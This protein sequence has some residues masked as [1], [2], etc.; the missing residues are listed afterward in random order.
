[1]RWNGETPTKLSVSHL[2]IVSNA[3]FELGFSGN[4]TARGSYAWPGNVTAYLSQSSTTAVL[5]CTGAI[6]S[7][8][9]DSSTS[10]MSI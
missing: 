10:R 9:L 7:A 1:M 5:E 3:E 2:S 8:Q 6:S 4:F